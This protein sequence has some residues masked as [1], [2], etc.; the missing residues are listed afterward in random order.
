M[1]KAPTPFGVNWRGDNVVDAIGT[2]RVSASIHVACDTATIHATPPEALAASPRWVLAA[3]ILTS[4]LA[5]VDG[6]VVNVGLPVIGR[7]LAADAGA[8]PWIINAYLLPLSALLLLGGAAGDRFGRKRLLIAGVA[9]FAL[10]SVICALAPT[11]AV[12][13]LGRFLQGAGAAMLMPNSLAILGQT[14]SGQ[15]RGQA[16][17]IWASAGAMAGALGP[18]LGGWLVDL[19]GWRGIFLINLPLAAAAI[20]LA[21]RHVPEDEDDGGTSLDITGGVLATLSLGGLTWALTVGSGPAGWTP[22]AVVL[23]IV[24]AGLG[25]IFLIIEMRNGDRAM[26]PLALFASR[27]FVGL[28]LL[29]LLL[30]GALGAL[31][32]MLPYVLIEGA[33]YSSTG[34]GAALLPLPLVLSVVSPKMGALAGRVGSRRLLAAGPVVVAMGFLLA[35][36]IG[37]TADYWTDVLPCVVVLAL[38]LSCAVAPLTTAVLA[39]VDARH[40][41]S[42][43][44]FNSAVA[45]TGGLV[46]TALLGAVLAAHDAS[47]IAAFHLAL[48][49]AAAASLA[50]AMAA[51][52]LV[53]R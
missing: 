16:I 2:W 13:L 34:A 44:G 11:L 23:G 3:T 37:N 1:L 6:S 49:A 38:G 45:R 9:L 20:W 51:F 8:L 10:A 22:I 14:F 40:T 7:S 24:A 18:V 27:S 5:F 29:T 15:A 19:G 52:A 50:A 26:M 31:L 30:Y 43:S 47:L 12:M 41:G 17:G 42:A 4:A 39:S 53:D 48:L 28:T 36:R 33:G 25:A 32:V 46:A 35:L 21:W